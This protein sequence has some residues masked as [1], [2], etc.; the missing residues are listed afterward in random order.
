MFCYVVLC[1]CYDFAM[2]CNVFAMILL[3]FAML[4]YVIVSRNGNLQVW[5]A[6]GLAAAVQKH[7]A[8]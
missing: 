2:F 5:P 3:C 1:V 6:A 8:H 4:C 7:P